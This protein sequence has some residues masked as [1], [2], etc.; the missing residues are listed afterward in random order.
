VLGGSGSPE[1]DTWRYADGLTVGI[2]PSAGRIEVPGADT[3]RAPE[4][5]TSSAYA[6]G[7]ASVAAAGRKESPED[8]T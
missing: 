2:D 4:E 1:L 3:S 5:A 6:D 8:A 7:L